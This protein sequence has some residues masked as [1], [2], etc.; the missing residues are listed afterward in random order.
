[1]KY[2][3]SSKY[4]KSEFTDVLYLQK[5]EV[6][7]FVSNI[8][9]DS[10]IRQD[11][12]SST[13]MTTE[14]K[15][16]TTRSNIEIPTPMGE[17]LNMTG[18]LPNPRV[19]FLI[20]VGDSISSHHKIEYKHN[21][22]N[23]WSIDGYLKVIGKTYYHKPDISDTCWVIEAKNYSNADTSAIFYFSPKYGFVYFNY[24]MGADSIVI[25]L[26]SIEEE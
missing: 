16:S 10:E 11:P 20:K 8:K 17:Y 6:D 25:A 5:Y 13:G 21:P 22:Y 14:A 9:W 23:G 26:K 4:S 24:Q 12:G 7:G 18:L 1:M 15:M 2:V 19:Q 3:F